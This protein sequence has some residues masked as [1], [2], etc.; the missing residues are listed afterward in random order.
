MLARAYS[1]RGEPKEGLRILEGSLVWAEE[2]G[3]RFFDAEVYRTR[4]ELLLLAQR[5]DE[6]EQS[7]QRALETARE[8]KA[9]M[10]ELRAAC[11][12]ARLLRDQGRQAEAHDLLAPVYSWF[13]EGFDTRDL[14]VARALLDRLSPSPAPFESR[15]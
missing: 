13:S 10:W 15:A 4:A 11:G 14:Q 6:A 8:Q 12:L 5:Q 9:R 7:Y 3:S 2:T 1:R